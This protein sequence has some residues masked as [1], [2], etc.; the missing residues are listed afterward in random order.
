MTLIT[1][2]F[3][4]F[5]FLMFSK[6][7][8]DLCHPCHP[9][10][11]AFLLVLRGQQNIMSTLYITQQ[12]AVLSKTSERLNVTLN[13]E[14]ISEIPLIKVSQV[15]VF[16]NVLITPP[17]LRLLMRHEIE[18][19]HLTQHGTY[20]GRTQ[21]DISRNSLLRIAQYQ[22]AFDPKR[23][24]ALA[25]CFVVGKLANLRAMLIDKVE[26]ARKP[27]IKQ[28]LKRIKSAE[29]GAQKARSLDSVRAQEGEGSAAYF[30]VFQQMIKTPAFTFDTRVRRPPTDPV[31]AML[32]FGYTLLANTMYTAVNIV[33]FDPYIGYL[34]AE[35]YGRPS[36]PLDLIEAF[37][38]LIVDTMV[39]ICLNKHILTPKDFQPAENNACLLTDEGRKTFLEQYEQRRATE[40]THPVLNRKITYQQSFEQQARLLAKTL[41]GEL[42]TYPPLLMT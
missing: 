33:G 24:L 27:E 14:L 2:I 28:A 42:E 1:R 31:N 20:L 15:V 32:S 22:A 36:L 11:I 10:S 6:I 19:C 37:R 34:H 12:G 29:K 9:C 5:S 4:D 39:L 23:R 7:R 16:G 38:P 13:K 26:K 30:S 41:Q 8:V 18:I 25:R 21:P 40:F 35:E 17:T 3:T